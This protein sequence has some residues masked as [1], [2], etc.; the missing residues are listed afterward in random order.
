MCTLCLRMTNIWG[1]VRFSG[2]EEGGR[3]TSEVKQNLSRLLFCNT[4]FGFL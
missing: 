4:V 2:A 1:N 3:Q